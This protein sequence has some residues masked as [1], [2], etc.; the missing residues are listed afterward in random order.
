M[1]ERVVHARSEV[2]CRR[3]KLLLAKQIE[4]VAAH[5]GSCASRDKKHLFT[6]LAESSVVCAGGDKIRENGHGERPTVHLGWF[7][8]GTLGHRSIAV[9]TWRRGSRGFGVGPEQSVAAEVI[10]RCARP[11]G[12]LAASFD[13]VV[14]APKKPIC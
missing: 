8:D 2:W 10:G 14:L 1:L 5:L 11:S 12:G 9:Q 4:G 6:P 7:P 13:P 3:E